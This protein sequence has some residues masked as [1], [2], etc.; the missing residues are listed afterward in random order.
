MRL[1]H[2]WAAESSEAYVG[3]LYIQP[4]VVFAGTITEQSDLNISGLGGQSVC[5]KCLCFQGNP[6]LHYKRAAQ[7]RKNGMNTPPF[8]IIA[9]ELGGTCRFLEERLIL[10]G[11][12]ES[13][14]AVACW[15]P[16]RRQHGP[17][18]LWGGDAQAR[19]AKGKRLGSSSPVG[20]RRG[21][22]GCS[23]SSSATATAAAR[24]PQVF[25]LAHFNSFHLPS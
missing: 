11:P 19:A 9:L 23:S 16:G 6:T 5:V 4:S 1:K 3:V 17:S 12:W 20:R 10:T 24:P 8:R 21:S 7:K 22:P 18:S 2:S 25:K 13:R 14:S 15:M